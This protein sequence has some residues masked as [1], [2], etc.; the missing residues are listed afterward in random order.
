MPAGHRRVRADG[1]KKL[2]AFDDGHREFRSPGSTCSARACVAGC[3]PRCSHRRRRSRVLG[4]LRQVLPDSR[5][6][7]CWFHKIANVLNALPRSA[8]PGAKAALA[9]IWNAKE[10]E[11]ARAAA[12]TFAADYAS[13]CPK[14]TAKVT[15]DLE[16]LLAFS[17]MTTGRALIHL[18]TTRSSRPSPPCGS[19]TESPRDPAPARPVSR[20]RSHS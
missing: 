5:E 7:R 16:V 2:V 15:Y 18:H 9:E 6:Q 17:S 12:K 11:H 3:T 1:T 19:G 10:K 20:R 14:A 13:K 4:S 8:Q